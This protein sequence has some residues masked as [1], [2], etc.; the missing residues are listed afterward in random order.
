MSWIKNRAFTIVLR[1]Q[2]LLTL[3]IVI[4][5]GFS[6]DFHSAISALLGGMVSLVSSAAFAVIISRH[7]GY[8]AN[9]AIRTAVKAE[10]VKICLIV[11]L[12]WVV[13]KSYEGVNALIF[14]GTFVLTI[15]VHSMALFVSDNIKSKIDQQK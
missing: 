6:S 3:T 14:I 7:E 2:L 11:I 12:L 5:F 13:L 15:L 4:V 1:A 10:I 9:G 8:T